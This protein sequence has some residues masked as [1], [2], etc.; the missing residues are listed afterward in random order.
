MCRE[1]G[2][3]IVTS[4]YYLNQAINLKSTE[5]YKSYLRKKLAE[6]ILQVSEVHQTAYAKAMSDVY[7]D[8]AKEMIVAL[9]DTDRKFDLE[10]EV[11]RK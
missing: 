11:A 4:Y 1:K 7:F 5:E 2:D 10:F 3:N 8:E 6:C 9:D